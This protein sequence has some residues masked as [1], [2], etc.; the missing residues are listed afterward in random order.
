MERFM[1]RI[2]YLRVLIAILML[3]NV[4][5]I[6]AF[7]GDAK[8]TLTKTEFVGD[9][10]YLFYDLAGEPEQVFSIT[11]IM[12]KRSDP[13]YQYAPKF[14]TGDVGSSMFSGTG[15][16][17]AW[18]FTREFPAGIDQKDVYFVVEARASGETQAAGGSNTILWIAGGAVV[19]GGIV[20]LLLLN[21]SS[22]SGGG[23]QTGSFPP[24]PGR[25]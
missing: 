19:A 10:V 16:R 7:A 21:N 14:V 22:N 9:T 15:W 4:A 13:K 20:A 3:C 5:T 6:R 18:N 12:K 8:V 1:S 2:K 24:P 23:T 11:L 17:I 25:P